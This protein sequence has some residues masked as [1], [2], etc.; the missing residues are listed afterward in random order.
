MNGPINFKI[1][2]KKTLEKKS[3]PNLKDFIPYIG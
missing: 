3:K 2:Q 1:E